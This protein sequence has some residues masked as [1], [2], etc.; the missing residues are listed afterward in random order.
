MLVGE[1]PGKDEE[2]KTPFLGSSGQLLDTI[3]HDAGI[4]RTE[5]F[6]TNV[7]RYRPP[8]NKIEA[9]FEDSACKH[10]GAFIREGIAELAAEIR[11]VRPNVIVALGNTAFYALANRPS[12]KAGISSWRGSELQVADRLATMAEP[13]GHQCVLIPTYH[14]AGIL[15]AWEN[16][17]VAVHDLRVR[18]SRYINQPVVQTPPYEFITSPSYAQVTAYLQDL[19]SRLSLCQGDLLR[20][21]VDIETRAGHIACIGLATSR[22]SAICIPLMCRA[23]PTGYFS[24]EE[25]FSIVWL[26]HQVLTHP[27]AN[28]VGQNF[29][30]DAQYFAKHYGYVPRVRDDTMLAQHVAYPGVSK[31]LDFLSSMYCDYHKYWKDDGKE[32]WDP[33]SDEGE[34]RG[35]VYNCTDAVVTYE[36]MDVL[37]TVINK[38]GLREQYSFQME[39]FH[40]VLPLMLRGV[41]IDLKHRDHL[42]GEL[43]GAMQERLG[44]VHKILGHELNP[45]SPKQMKALFYEDLAQPVQRSRKTRGAD[46][47]FSIT[48]DEEALQTLARKEPLLRDFIRLIVEYR[49]LGVFLSTFVQ[50]RLGPDLRMRC[51]FNIAGTETYRFSSSEDAFGSGTNLQNLPRGLEE[52]E[53]DI[54]ELLQ[55]ELPNIRRLFLPDEGYTVG[56]V[57]LAG[58]DAQVVAWEADDPILKQIFR[59]GLK[60]HVE[61]GKLMYPD[62][63][64][65]NPKREPY[66]T[67]VK[68]GG[69][70]SN[71]GASPHTLSKSLNI[72]IS[73]AERFQRRWFEIHPAIREWQR[74]VD[75]DLQTTRTVRNRFG[76][77]RYYFDRI[78][79][80]LPEGLAWVPQSTVAC[81]A[82]R[83][84]VA[85]AALAQLG[86]QMLLQVH[87]SLVFQYPTRNEAAILPL[88]RQLITIPVP[89]QPD[90]L[91]IP[92][93]LKTSTRSWGD[94]E[95]RKWPQNVI[96][97]P[98]GSSQASQALVP[99]RA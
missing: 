62:L 15:R 64:R 82:N 44:S 58:A 60:L 76:Y 31:G 7:S 41:R 48:L 77:R 5:C 29:S 40:H 66:Y 16:R 52:E 8:A 83:A 6:L 68:V 35:W 80:I 45:R 18:V 69:H 14:P 1:A 34:Q 37:D 98:L 4:A 75:S 25:E 99:S 70:A 59:E 17:Q 38:L 84:L 49:S 91:V 61:N 50:A 54:T 67:R 19:L 86:F 56:E 39:L 13:L 3:L 93:G 9:F 55:Y 42:S 89:Y 85:S 79:Q 23:R 71:Y 24:Q 33:K 22:L 96:Q 74:R 32:A 28:V 53:I 57:D 87:D 81:V 27:L 95:E 65:E 47:L 43:I 10:P 46:G 73:D 72:S 21:S 97:L 94:A 20:V 30:Y 36:C 90:N 26:L 92:W 63:M 12:G 88:L 78:E 2:G 11:A 51:Y